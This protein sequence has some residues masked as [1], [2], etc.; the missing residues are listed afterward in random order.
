[1]SEAN[2]GKGLK[3]KNWMK[4]VFMYFVPLAIIIVYIVGLINFQWK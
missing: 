1:M 4:P 2:N 3:V